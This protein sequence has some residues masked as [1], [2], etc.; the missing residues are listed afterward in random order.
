MP[1]CSLYEVISN[2]CIFKDLKFSVQQTSELS[3]VHCVKSIRHSYNFHEDSRRELLN[4][5]SFPKKFMRTGQN[6]NGRLI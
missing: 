4:G 2:K 3:V 1:S 5:N 6:K